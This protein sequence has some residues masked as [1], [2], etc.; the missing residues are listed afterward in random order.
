MGSIGTPPCLLPLSNRREGTQGER[1]GR[2]ARVG[3]RQRV[4]GEIGVDER[5]EPPGVVGRSMTCPMLEDNTSESLKMA[6][7]MTDKDLRAPIWE[8]TARSD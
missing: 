5:G 4:A 2:Q 1:T 6:F 7:L 8:G 3:E